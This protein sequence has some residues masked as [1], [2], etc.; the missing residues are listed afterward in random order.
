VRFHYLRDPLFLFC[1]ALYFVNRFVFKRIWPTGFVH[2]HLNDLICIP[3]WVPIMLFIQRRVGWREGDYSP[4]RGEIV[5]P[6]I[7]WSCIFEI[8]LPQTD[9]FGE[10]CVA[11]HLDVVYYALGAL[12]AAAFWTWWYRTVLPWQGEMGA[13]RSRAGRSARL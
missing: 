5:I 2:E 11:D 12:I 6:L 13:S 1:V 8:M 7:L 4:Q 10:L 9:W 3:F